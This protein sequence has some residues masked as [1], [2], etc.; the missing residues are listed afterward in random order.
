MAGKITLTVTKGEL[1]GKTFEYEEPDRVYVG[2]QEDCGI[3]LPENTVSRYHC[4]LDINPPEVSLQDFGSLNGTYLNDMKIGQRDRN[5]SWEE[6]KGE[7]R[8]SYELHDGDRVRLG[9][10]CELTCAVIKAEPAEDNGTVVEENDVPDGGPVSEAA[11]DPQAVLSVIAGSEEEMKPE[12][13]VGSTPDEVPE[14]EMSS[15]EEVKAGTES[16]A[17]PESEAEP[18]PGAGYEAKDASQPEPEKVSEAEPDEAKKEP[19]EEPDESDEE[20]E[21]L[22]VSQGE[23]KICGVCGNMFPPSSP[24]DTLCMECR[25]D[26]EKMLGAILAAVIGG[27]LKQEPSGPAPIKGFDKI[28]LLG[29]G[30]MGEV[31]KVKEQSSGKLYALK[32]LLPKA[33]MDE[34]AKA[35]FL[36]EAKLSEYLDHKNVIR[37]YQTGSSNGTLF[38]LMDLCEGGSADDL[39]KLHGGT[40]PLPLATYI[41]LQVLEGLD[42]VHHVDVEAEIRKRGVFGTKKSMHAKGLVHRDLKPGNIF[43][44]DRGDHPTAKVADF[45]MAKAFQAAGFSTLSDDKAVKGTIP[46]MPRQQAIDC[47]YAKPEVDVWAAA[48]SYYHMLTGEFPKNF[49]AGQNMWLAIVSEPVVPIR[50]RDPAIPEKIAMVIDRALRENPEIGCKS[51][52]VLRDDLIRALPKEV[53]EYCEVT[54]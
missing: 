36:R 34:K 14:P 3:V 50:K 37:T 27:A 8:T 24:D 13:V 47:R 46:F 42:Y 31:W 26:R 20:S 21:Y 7:E 38:I 10:R 39:M 35:L 41:M 32:T 44:S 11:V 18:Q 19:A 40:L 5:Q 4:L 22:S 28:A 48:A 30:G 6:A 25:Q 17:E 53:K 15:V 2:R 51:A 23:Q 9:K 1:E 16:V 33:A 52:A 54:T 29:R 12:S 45:G 43:L 49:R